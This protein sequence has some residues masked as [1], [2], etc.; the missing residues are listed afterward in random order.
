MPSGA[1]IA[2]VFWSPLVA[3]A[4]IA[5]VA[6]ITVVVVQAPATPAPSPA[7]A[8]PAAADPSALYGRWVRSG[9]ACTERWAVMKV[10]AGRIVHEQADVVRSDMTLAGAT[11]KALGVFEIKYASQNGQFVGFSTFEL[12]DAVTLMVSG[13]LLQPDGVWRKC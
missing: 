8:V 5:V 7:P 1:G 4:V 6:A 10:S 9:E 2:R 3:V 13:Y 11:M 12:K